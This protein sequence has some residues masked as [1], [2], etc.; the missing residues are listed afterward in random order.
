MSVW[1]GEQSLRFVAQGKDNECTPNICPYTN[2]RS[3]NEEIMGTEKERE[4][5]V[6]A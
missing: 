5:I 3:T 6:L 2:I 1:R 4:I